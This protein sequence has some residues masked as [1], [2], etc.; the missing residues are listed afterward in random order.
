MLRSQ[1]LQMLAHILYISTSL[2]GSDMFDRSLQRIEAAAS[3]FSN[4]KH[5]V[6]RSHEVSQHSRQPTVRRTATKHHAN[7]RAINSGNN[8]CGSSPACNCLGSV[9]VVNFV[10]IHID[11][12]SGEKQK[13]RVILYGTGQ[14][15]VESVQ[16][17]F[18]IL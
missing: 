9:N 5:P 7:K 16:E 8:H 13:G 12:E 4:T 15:S 14:R 18:Q 11:F 10:M 2:R 6:C 3:T 1:L 17:I